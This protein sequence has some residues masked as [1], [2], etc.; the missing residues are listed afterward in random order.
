MNDGYTYRFTWSAD[1]HEHVALC[2]TTQSESEA[3]ARIQIDEL[4]RQ[5]GWDPAD[6]STIGT[7]IHSALGDE[8]RGS[9]RIR[10]GQRGS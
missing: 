5:A 4:L 9:I 7:E 8:R 1:D 10:F 2:Q 3:D 6:K